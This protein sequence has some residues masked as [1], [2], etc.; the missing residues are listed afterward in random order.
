MIQNR[1]KCSSLEVFQ[2]RSD[3][4]NRILRG[5]FDAKDLQI[6]TKLNFENLLKSQNVSI[7]APRYT[8]NAASILEQLTQDMYI[9]IDL[10][11]FGDWDPFILHDA[12]KLLRYTFDN[13]FGG[14][15]KEIDQSK[16]LGFA[17]KE[18]IR[19]SSNWKPSAV[20]AREFRAARKNAI[21]AFYALHNHLKIDGHLSD[22]LIKVSSEDKISTATFYELLVRN[23]AKKTEGTQYET[24]ETKFCKSS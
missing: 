5:A 1:S 11:K 8:S 12:L 22:D 14:T 10:F 19:Q 13:L 17:Y 3:L 24:I 2:S 16:G 18:C 9:S 7:N 20:A 21:S 4:S 6:Q 15:E 23:E